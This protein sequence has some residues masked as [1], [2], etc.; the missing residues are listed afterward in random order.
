MIYNKKVLEHFKNPKNIGKIKN[1]DGVGK[2]GSLA[3]GDVMWLYIKVGRSK[4]G[5]EI[6]SDVKFETFGCTAAIAVSS[7]ITELAKGKNLRQAS[8]IGREK[9]VSSLGGLPP[10][11][12]HCSILAAD[13]LIEAIYNYLVKTKKPIS[14]NLEVKHQRIEREKE[15][16][17]EKYKD[18]VQKEESFRD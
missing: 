4:K 11:K 15:L 2:V 8:L 10:V 6:I 5:E 14:K 9:V 17:E 1:A 12:I 7:M 3:C 18:W 13:A 16:V